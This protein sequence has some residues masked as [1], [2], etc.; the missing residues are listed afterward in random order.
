MKLKK[1][2][3]SLTK[4]HED[5]PKK[6]D[7]IVC[8]WCGHGHGDYKTLFGGKKEVLVKCPECG[9]VDKYINNNG[10]YRVEGWGPYNPK[11]EEKIEGINKYLHKNWENIQRMAR[12]ERPNMKFPQ[13]HPSFY[14]MKPDIKDYKNKHN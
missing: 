2:L 3:E 4:K 5:A 9:H 11:D 1:I 6:R 13:K 14:E 8:P 12:G 10:D 7:P